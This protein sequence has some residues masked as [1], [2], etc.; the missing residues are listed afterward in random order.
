[1]DFEKRPDKYVM[2]LKANGSDDASQ[3]EKNEGLCQRP[4]TWEH[5]GGW[6]LRER[7]HIWLENAF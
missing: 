3:K 6:N 7:K 5:K 4:A 2:Y 1:M